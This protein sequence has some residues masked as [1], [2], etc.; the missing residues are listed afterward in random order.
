[1][2]GIGPIRRTPS[3]AAAIGVAAECCTKFS[4]E[5]D[6]QTLNARI[7][8]AFSRRRGEAGMTDEIRFNRYRQLS[9]Q[10]GDHSARTL[11]DK[12]QVLALTQPDT[13]HEI[14]AFI[15]R[16]L[17]PRGARESGAAHAA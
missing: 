12:L 17:T 10:I 2:A 16:G 8:L 9:T 7:I 3:R 14:E 1:L 4:S 11:L 5:G 13:L 15:D 6:L